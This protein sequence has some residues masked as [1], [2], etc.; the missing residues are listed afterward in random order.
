MDIKSKIA[1][2]LLFTLCVNFFA[3]PAA[4]ASI[5]FENF[6]AA[7]FKQV[8]ETLI[9]Q[10]MAMIRG[11]LKQ[12]AVRM[13]TQ[14]VN[15]LVG[16]GSSGTAMFISNWSSFLIDQPFNEADTYLN[17]FFSNSLG[18]ADSVSNYSSGS[19]GVM[20]NYSSY[21]KGVAASAI[22]SETPK[23]NLSQYA[24]SPGEVFAK[25][26]WQG[27]MALI[28]NP[29]NNQFGYTILAQKNFQDRVAAAKEKAQTKAIS[30]QGYVGKESNGQTITPGSLVKD[31]QA[32]VQD[33][34]NKVV[35]GAQGIPEVIS[36]L[37]A[38]L[39]MDTIQQGVGNAQRRVQKELTNT[40]GSYRS[41]YL[42][43]SYTSQFNSRY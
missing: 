28:S 16:G 6:G 30:Y 33:L 13:I 3:A 5:W 39:I 38:R 4:H 11:M 2:F 19:E 41:K 32:D 20:G 42:N 17:D 31:M 40:V 22:Y 25:G 9:S 1:I 23:Y 8:M 29:A 7:G 21:L 37:A 18:G 15:K 12:M 27:F 36:S 14:Q 26:N 43:S 35:A 10:I 34:G 24:S